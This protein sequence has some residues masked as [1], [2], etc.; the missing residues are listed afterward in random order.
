MQKSVIVGGYFLYNI[1]YIFNAMNTMASTSVDE[2][3]VTYPIE[4]STNISWTIHNFSAID[5]NAFDSPIFEPLVN[6]NEHQF[7][8]KIN[9]RDGPMRNSIGIHLLWNC[10]D[11]EKLEI[12]FRFRFKS[13]VSDLIITRE[14]RQLF[15]NSFKGWGLTQATPRNKLVNQHPNSQHPMKDTVTI[16]ADISFWDFINNDD[17]T[18]SK[19]VTR[20]IC[21]KNDIR[22]L[23]VLHAIGKFLNYN[24]YSDVTF[25]VN[26]QSFP[27]HM[28]ILAAHSSVFD[29]IFERIK[30]NLDEPIVYLNNFN[31]DAFYEVM[32]YLY[33]GRIKNLEKYADEI[34]R[35]AISFK[36]NNL[37]DIIKESSNKGLNFSN[38]DFSNL[39]S[40]DEYNKHENVNLNN[41]D[42]DNV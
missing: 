3:K 30:Q 17:K 19:K 38:N 4:L 36:I 2:W 6:H 22:A 25:V 15:N 11:M 27:A 39:V 16:Y 26:G 9:T 5:T 40:S 18:N 10:V 14:L 8:I 1:I 7:K 32:R 23:N 12:K 37:K 33:T 21:N 29:R 34:S 42:F 13:E 24:K 35:I 28:A 41:N 31:Y 20:S